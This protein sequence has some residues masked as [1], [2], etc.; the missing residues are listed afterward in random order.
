MFLHVQ[1][2][3]LKID[4]HIKIIENLLNLIPHK[5]VEYLQTKM[6]VTDNQF[7]YEAE[8]KLH[9]ININ[10]HFMSFS[11]E[12]L[13]LSVDRFSSIFNVYGLSIR[14]TGIFC[15]V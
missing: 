5:I 4:F 11:N 10:T 14:S 7:L 1:N 12:C 2:Y 15:A 8:Y 9:L 3:F 13:P 6:H